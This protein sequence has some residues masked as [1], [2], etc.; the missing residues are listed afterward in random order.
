MYWLHSLFLVFASL[1]A[2]AAVR[3]LARRPFFL[4]PLGT[5]WPGNAVLDG[6]IFN[7]HK[8]E[9]RDWQNS[10][11]WRVQL[12]RRNVTLLPAV[13][14]FNFQW[15]LF[16]F[17][18]FFFYCTVA[19]L[20]RGRWNVVSLAE[21]FSRPCFFFRFIIFK[22]ICFWSLVCCAFIIINKPG[23]VVFFWKKRIY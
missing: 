8:T 11:E 7:G 9:T 23:K 12:G 20:M 4:P 10:L 19:S 22:G 1:L 17:F 6:M 5:A 14:F 21:C 3:C 13:L 15:T 2:V 18:F 16:F